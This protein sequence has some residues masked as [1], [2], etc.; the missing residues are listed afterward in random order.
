[1][2]LSALDILGGQESISWKMTWFFRSFS[3][4]YIYIYIYQFH[5]I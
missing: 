1:M 2:L 5:V 4:L 3:S